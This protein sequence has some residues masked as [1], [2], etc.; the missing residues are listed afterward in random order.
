M[1]KHILTIV[2][3]ERRSNGWI[4]TE[5]LLVVAVLWTLM[6]SLLVD[7]YTYRSPLGF[8]ITDTYQVSIDRLSPGMP[9]YLPDSLLSSSEGEDLI[10]L[11]NNL[12]SN[13]QVEGTAMAFAATPYGTSSTWGVLMQAEADTSQKLQYFQRFTVSPEY[14]DLL[15]MTDKE[16]RSLRSAVERD[17]RRVVVTADLE[18]AFWEGQSAVG[19]TV[20]FDPAEAVEIPVVA[21]SALKRWGEYDKPEPCYYNVLSGNDLL[22]LIRDMQP[23]GVECLL[24]MKPGFRP[25][26]M[27]PF[28]QSISDRLKVNNIHLSSVAPL[29]DRR[30]IVLKYREDNMKKKS[31]L[32]GFM[33]ISVLFG[34]IGSF[35]LRTQHRRGQMGLRC[36]LGSSRRQLQWLLFVEGICLLSL[37]IPFVLLYLMNMLYFD[38]PDTYR[39]GYT[40]WRFAATFFGAY[41]LMAG[42]IALGIWFPTRKMIQME[43]AE[44]L[45]YE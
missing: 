36:A 5:L 15:R 29:N 32:V 22:N 41:S 42:M 28:L 9:G 25:E 30:T 31:A 43:P 35:W 11:M 13:P 17:G 8:D 18:E 2:W 6:D 45:R 12:K 7:T 21:V 24:R 27:E 26:E 1:I 3:N 33:L 23:M 16:G 20:K 19:K 44:A 40:G 34:I 38:M 14:F 37:T 4:F 39:L 10:R